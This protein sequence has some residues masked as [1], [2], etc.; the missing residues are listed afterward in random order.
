MGVP[1][2]PLQ[3]W[4]KPITFTEDLTTM[5]TNSPKGV[6]WRFTEEVNGSDVG[7]AG[8]SSDRAR[9]HS[10]LPQ[11]GFVLTPPEMVHTPSGRGTPEPQTPT[12]RPSTIRSTT[13]A[14]LKH[15]IM[16]N[17]LYQKQATRLWITSKDTEGVILRKARGEYLACP[18]QLLDTTFGRVC[19]EM[20]L[21]VS[22]QAQAKLHVVLTLTSP[23]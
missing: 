14:S 11:N 6:P 5:P 23:L 2:Q 3:S 17:H 22:T 10:G 21:S 1:T 20:N 18:A 4:E 8:I 9:A 16:V 12:G 7:P 15:E 19:A 13:L